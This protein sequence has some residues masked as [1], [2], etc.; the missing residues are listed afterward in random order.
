MPKEPCHAAACALQRCLNAHV[1]DTNKAACEGA[2]NAYKECARKYIAA[3]P[4]DE[5]GLSW[6]LE[7]EEKST[8]QAKEDK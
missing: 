2:L 7:G 8:A 4:N 6:L 3:H 5:A 1:Y